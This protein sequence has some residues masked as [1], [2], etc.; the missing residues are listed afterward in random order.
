MGGRGLEKYEN[1]HNTNSSC[2]IK[3]YGWKKHWGSDV[4]HHSH[5]RW[6]QLYPS[7]SS[8]KS[9]QPLTS[10]GNQ[11]QTSTIVNVRKS[12]SNVQ[13]QP[14]LLS[15]KFIFSGSAHRRHGKH[16]PFLFVAALTY[17]KTIIMPL[18]SFLSLSLN[19]WNPVTNLSQVAFSSLLIIP[20]AFF[21]NLSNGPYYP[22]RTALHMTHCSSWGLPKVIWALGII[23]HLFQTTLPVKCLPVFLAKAWHQSFRLGQDVAVTSTHLAVRTSCFIL[24]IG[25]AT[26][27]KITT[28][29]YLKLFL[30]L[31]H[32]EERGRDD[33][34]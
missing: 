13:Y 26:K 24:A 25:N 21:W 29:F 30:L 4:V 3:E 17:L 12:V 9:V 10:A 22:S 32:W 16:I 11:V 34:L 7:R 2:S 20:V 15:F 5:P 27:W 28:D 33:I 8:W 1:A 23:S 19:N 18:L 14:P 31:K 6:D